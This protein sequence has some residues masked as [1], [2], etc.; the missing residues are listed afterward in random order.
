MAERY[1]VATGNWSDTATWDGGTLPTSSDDVYA[2]NFTVTIDQDVTVLSVRTT[3]GTT[4]VAGGGFTLSDGRTLNASIIAG[5]SNCVTFSASSPAQAWI[6]GNAVGGE[7]GIGVAHAGTGTLY[8]VGNLT[9][10]DSPSSHGGRVSSSGTLYVTGDLIG[11]ISGGNNSRGLHVQAGGTV[12]I[13]GNVIGRYSSGLHNTINNSNITINGNVSGGVTGTLGY[14]IRQQGNGTI[15]INGNVTCTILAGVQHEG[16]GSL[17]I[18]GNVTGGTTAAGIV[19]TNLGT[20]TITGDVT[21]G[22]GAAAISNTQGKV[23]ITGNVYAVGSVMAL[24]N[25]TTAGIMCINGNLYASATGHCPFALGKILVDRTRDQE[26]KFRTDSGGGTPGAERVLYTALYLG[27]AVAGGS[28]DSVRTVPI[29][30]L[31]GAVVSGDADVLRLAQI[32]GSGGA[33]TGGRA[34]AYETLPPELLAIVDTYAWTA[35][36]RREVAWTIE[37]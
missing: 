10:G 32:T 18:T 3:A 11:S 33:V 21:A 37:R 35:S 25:G 15:T 22:S 34:R 6:N 27:G 14:G 30:A 28:A 24:D 26:I 17:V 1:A 23:F 9:G 13:S 12:I 4:A 2:N 8:V 7:S 5:T 36:I 16:T 31:G 20:V 29:E 19:S